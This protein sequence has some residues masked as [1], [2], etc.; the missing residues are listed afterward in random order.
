MSS[1]YDRVFIANIDSSFHLNRRMRVESQKWKHLITSLPVFNFNNVDTQSTSMDD[2]VVSQLFHGGDPN[3][4]HHSPLVCRTNQWTGFYMIG[5][6]S[7]K[8]LM[9]LLKTYRVQSTG[10]PSKDKKI[11]NNFCSIAVFLLN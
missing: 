9:L 2:V 7:M 1:I 11:K 4:L 10:V 6:S 8:E 3:H 5:A